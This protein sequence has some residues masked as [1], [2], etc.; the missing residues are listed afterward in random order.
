MSGQ[1]TIPRPLAW[2]ALVLVAGVVLFLAPF[3]LPGLIGQGEARPTPTPPALPTP[4]PAAVEPTPDATPAEV[5]YIVQAGD[6][7]SAIAASYGVTVDQILAA[8]PTI[9][10]PNQI[11]I[12]DR[13]VIPRPPPSEIVDGQLTPPP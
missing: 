8:N 4:T 7:L 13:I 10:D 5:V 11:A 6:T 1:R 3:V 2:A 12:G 9:S